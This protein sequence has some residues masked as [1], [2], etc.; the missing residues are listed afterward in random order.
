MQDYS[1]NFKSPEKKN[2]FLYIINV[3]E[4]NEEPQSWEG[5]INALQKHSKDQFD[6]FE[7]KFKKYIFKVLDLIDKNSK[8]SEA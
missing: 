1:G 5:T 6:S 8:R 4:E 2:P 3:Q 7:S